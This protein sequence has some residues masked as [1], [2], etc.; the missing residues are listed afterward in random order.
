MGKTLSVKNRLVGRLE[1]LSSD[2]VETLHAATLEVLQNTGV[3][4]R[5]TL[6]REILHEAGG[7]YDYLNL[8]WQEIHANLMTTVV[9]SRLS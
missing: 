8:K 1:V 7:L 6:A 3:Q 9:M 4:V 2:Q 5:S